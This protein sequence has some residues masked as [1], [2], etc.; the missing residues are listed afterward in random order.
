MGYVHWSTYLNVQ[1]IGNKD[2]KMQQE[3]LYFMIIHLAHIKRS[4][5]KIGG[6]VASVV[7]DGFS[8]HF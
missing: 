1:C 5:R 3:L 2:G 6:H 4:P 7:A 8:V